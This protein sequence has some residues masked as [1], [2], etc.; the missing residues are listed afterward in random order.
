MHIFVFGDA[1]VAA[2]TKEFVGT[3][4]EVAGKT[5]RQGFIDV[6]TKSASGWKLHFTK[7]EPAGKPE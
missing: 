4:G 6:F 7:A 2:Y 5:R 1:A 3:E